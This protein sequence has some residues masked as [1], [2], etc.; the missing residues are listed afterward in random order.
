MQPR[1]PN[2][3]PGVRE[4]TRRGSCPSGVQEKSHSDDTSL[5]GHGERVSCHRPTSTRWTV[6]GQVWPGLEIR[7][8]AMSPTVW[9]PSWHQQCSHGLFRRAGRAG[10]RRRRRAHNSPFRVGGVYENSSCHRLANKSIALSRGN[11]A[12][13]GDPCLRAGYRAVVTGRA[14]SCR[15]RRRCFRLLVNGMGPEKSGSPVERWNR[16]KLFELKEST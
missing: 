8:K 3:Q 9:R 7:V 1:W 10:F 15:W 11:A 12:Q 16:R 2:V 14:A 6:P 4:G 13:M 5:A